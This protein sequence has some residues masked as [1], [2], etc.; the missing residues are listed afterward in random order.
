MIDV[1]SPDNHLFAVA[2]IE[3]FPVVAGPNGHKEG[4]GAVQVAHSHLCC[5][6]GNE[7]FNAPVFLIAI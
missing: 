4:P 3:G 7:S 6:V 5:R 1:V 2:M